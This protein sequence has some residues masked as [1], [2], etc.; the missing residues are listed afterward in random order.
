MA[1]GSASSSPP[2]ISATELSYR[3]E[4]DLRTLS[5]AEEIRKDPSRVK[6]VKRHITR[7]QKL[8]GRTLGRRR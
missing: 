3:A 2:A 8:F 4:D 6:H 7:Q 1:K 5:R